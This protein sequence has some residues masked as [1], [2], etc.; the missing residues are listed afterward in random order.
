MGQQQLLLL[1]LSVIIV[2]IAIVVG[3]NMFQ[4]QAA[5]ANLDAVSNDL[6]DLG[7]RAQQFYVRPVSLGGGGNDFTGMT[8]QDLISHA[9][10]YDNE[11]GYYSVVSAGPTT[12]VIEGT[13]VRDG[14]DLAGP[15]HA[16]V[17]VY[18]D[19][20]LTIVVDNW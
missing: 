18:A 13:G 7:S 12:A 8:M 10:P 15:C 3:I 20:T 11:N 4:A 16:V 17:T 1:V 19:S 6:A 2:G 9:D 5:S 14:D